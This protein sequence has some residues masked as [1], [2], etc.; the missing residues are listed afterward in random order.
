VVENAT[1][2]AR[3]ARVDVGDTV[4]LFTDGVTEAMANDT[5]FFGDGRLRAALAE[6]AGAAA[7]DL[8]EGVVGAVRRFAGERRPHDD[9]TVLAVRCRGAG[10]E[11]EGV[12]RGA[13]CVRRELAEV[14]RACSAMERLALDAGLSQ[15]VIHCV[16]LALEEALTNVIAYAWSDD[17]P[18]E[19]ALRFAAS[20][21]TLVAEVEDDGRPFNP[22]DRAPPDLDAPLEERPIGGLGIHFV[23]TLMDEVEYRR[24]GGRNLLVM[25]KG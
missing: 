7:F 21:G 14:A 10:E 6:H 24:V 20:R 22:L 23:R 25:R 2:E 18:H 13:L 11:A 8:V 5:Q 4:F 19:I 9:L 12:A 3:Q 16:H 15:R 1:Y 17:E